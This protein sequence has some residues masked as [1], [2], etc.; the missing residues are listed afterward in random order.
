MKPLL[1]LGDILVDVTLG[2]ATTPLKMRLGGIVHAARGAWSLDRVYHTFYFA[3]EYLDKEINSFLSHHGC[4][5]VVKGGN[6]TGSSYTILVGEAKEVGNQGYEF[7]QRDLVRIAYDLQN[8][9]Q[10]CEDAL[11]IS[12]NYDIN[13]VLNELGK[14]TNFH[15]DVANNVDDFA[16]LNKLPKKPTTLFISTSSQLFSKFYTGD[17]KSFADLFRRYTKRLILKENRGGSRGIDFETHEIVYGTSQT[18]PIVHSV[19]VGDVYDTCYVNFYRH[20]SFEE[21]MALSSW[22]ATEYARTTFPDDFKNGVHDVLKT[23]LSDLL[24]LKGISLPWEQR[25][26]VNIYL[27][28]PDFSHIDTSFID[29]IERSLTYHNFSPRRPIKENGLMEADADLLRKRELFSKDLALLAECKMVIAILLGNDPGTLV[30]IG[31]AEGHGI[32]VILFDP[33][34]IAKNCMLV[35]LPH[36]VTS[37]PDVVISEVFRLAAK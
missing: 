11:L 19:G 20:R 24:S 29:Q 16:Y 5:K 22:V 27:A 23:D 36:I 9:S 1:I 13:K 4:P 3:P 6:V 17:F 35:S 33:Y 28:A 25:K 31:L 37:D 10:V 18:Q 21:A 14:E 15:L 2:S 34:N 30:E 32:P 12:G 7:L 8:I 26:K